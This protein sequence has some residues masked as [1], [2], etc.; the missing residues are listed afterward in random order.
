MEM[1]SYEIIFY[2]GHSFNPFILI[3][4]KRRVQSSL[5]QN[6][7]KLTIPGF[8][9]NCLPVYCGDIGLKKNPRSSIGPENRPQSAFTV[10]R[11]LQPSANYS[12]E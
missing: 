3:R 12:A 5:T 9:Y 7:L 11:A 10:F 6:C 2:K 4:N 8:P 1:K